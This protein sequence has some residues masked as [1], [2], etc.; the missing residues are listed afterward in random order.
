MS[1]QSFKARLESQGPKGAWTYVRLPFDVEDAWGSRARVSVRGTMNG[2]PFRSSVFPD[3]KGGHHMM[4]N[5]TMKAGAKADAGN[6]V[7]M[8]LEPDTEP[9]EVEI[10]RDFARAIRADTA[11]RKIFDAFAPSHRARYVEW[12]ESA[13]K[14]ETRERRIAKAVEM[15]REGRKRDD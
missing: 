6:T 9:R 12:I 3:G 8:V 11:A 10:P 15:I 2:F 14:E 1:K 5:K 7:A 13:K 4:V